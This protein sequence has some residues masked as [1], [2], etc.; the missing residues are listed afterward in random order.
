VVD[1][2]ST[3]KQ[4]VGDNMMVSVRGEYLA[5]PNRMSRVGGL[6]SS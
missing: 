1:A 5:F 3:V 4:S 6:K 2:H